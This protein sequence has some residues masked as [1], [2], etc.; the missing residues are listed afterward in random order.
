MNFNILRQI[1]GNT[2]IKSIGSGPKSVF[3]RNLSTGA[4]KMLNSTE[5]LGVKKFGP[6]QKQSMKD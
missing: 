1:S 3:Y 4:L 5:F 2:L 6:F